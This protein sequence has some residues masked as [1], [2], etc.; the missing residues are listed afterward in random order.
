[1]GFFGGDDKITHHEFRK[2][3]FHLKEK[4]FS[5]T[6]IEQVVST[7]RGDLD[8]EGSGSGISKEELRNGINWLKE[9]REGHHLDTH[10]IEIVE[11][12]LKKY[13]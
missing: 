11:E 2:A 8:E 3:L 10:Q 7:F 13:L 4:G 9:H 12:V 5:E 1:M 6:Q